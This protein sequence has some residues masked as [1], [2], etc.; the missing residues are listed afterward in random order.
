[1]RLRNVKNAIDIINNSTYVIKEPFD[2][3]KCWNKVFDNNNEIYLEIGTG[4]GDFIINEALR[5]PN[6]N[7]IGIEKYE[8]VIIRA[9]QKLEELNIDNLKLLCMDACDIEKVF[10]KEISKI[11]LNFSDPWPKN[12]HRN[13]RLTSPIFLKRYKNIVKNKLIIEM[14]TDNDNLFDYSLNEFNKMKFNIKKIDRDYANDKNNVS[15]TEY[16]KKFIK[17]NKNINYVKVEL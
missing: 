5:N 10:K 15:K 13:R 3:I 14:K 7:Y 1:M 8:S 17:K 4:K 2:N 12:K 11:Y 16:E 6:I 9:I